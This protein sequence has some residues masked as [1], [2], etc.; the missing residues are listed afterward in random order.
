MSDADGTNPGPSPEA[1]EAEASTTE[2][3]VAD[4]EIPSEAFISPDEPIQRS[5]APG[6]P[7]AAFISPDDPIMRSKDASGVVVAMDGQVHHLANMDDPHLEPEQVANILEYTAKA[8]RETGMVGLTVSPDAPHF[9]AVLK[10]YLA[11]YFG[12]RA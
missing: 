7:P 5:A 8:I 12:S 2:D 1:S 11:G 9:E 4:S 10:S 3:E 6:I